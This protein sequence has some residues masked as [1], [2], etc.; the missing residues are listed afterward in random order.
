MGIG[1]RK[2][3]AVLL[4]V[5]GAGCASYGEW[6]QVAPQDV[7]GV[8]DFPWC[9]PNRRVIAEARSKSPG[10]LIVAGGTW[11]G[12]ERDCSNEVISLRDIVRSMEDSIIR[13]GV[14][15]QWDQR[16]G[17]AVPPGDL[18]LVSITPSIAVACDSESGR[19]A[20]KYP[21]T[22]DSTRLEPGI[23]FSTVLRCRNPAQWF[24]PELANGWQQLTGAAPDSRRIAFSGGAI[25]F[26]Q[27]QEGWV[28]R[29]E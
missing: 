18:V 25:N 8:Y 28:T 23:G 10:P 13:S 19:R 6:R 2:A 15:K 1:M 21:G 20:R 17:H 26:R 27:T 24:S 7:T 5:V 14:T 22:L 29:R 12:R 11:E 9:G 4:V 3:V 16:G